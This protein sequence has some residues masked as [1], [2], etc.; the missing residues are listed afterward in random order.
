MRLSR[1]RSRPTT[2]QKNL[3]A[4]GIQPETSV[5]VARNSDHRP[6]RRSK[7]DTGGIKRNEI[8]STILYLRYTDAS[9]LDKHFIPNYVVIKN[10]KPILL[11]TLIFYKPH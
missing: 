9:E 4:P 2:T 11:V 10:T 3:V 7:L 5:S 8:V 6:Q 1:P